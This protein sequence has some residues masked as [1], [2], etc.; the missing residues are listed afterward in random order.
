MS[1]WLVLLLSSVLSF[2][3]VAQQQFIAGKDY[4]VIND[5]VRTSDATKIEVAEVFWYGCPHCNDFRPLVE[6]WKKQQPDDVY[7]RR[8]PAMWNK[9]MVTH[10]SIFYTA[11]ALDKLEVMHKTIFDAMHI[12]KK[13]LLKQ[14]EIFSLFAKHGVD[15]ATFNKA[16]SSFGVRSSVQQAE[17]RA[18]SYG[19]TG[20]PELIVNGKYRIAGGMAGSQPRMLQIANFLIAKERAAMAAGS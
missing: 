20:T 1:K 14:D 8:S 15:E 19:I 18:R 3:A 17:S 13:K 9:R 11:K 10:A 6:Q 2:T 16:F 7:V 5:P 4:A 12:H